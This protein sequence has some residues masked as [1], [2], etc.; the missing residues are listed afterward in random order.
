MTAGGGD[1]FDGEV[2]AEPGAGWHVVE[3]LEGGLG[4]EEFEVDAE[5]GGVG[6]GEGVYG[7]GEVLVVEAG[8][9]FVAADQA[10]V[11]LDDG[12]EGELDGTVVEHATE[13][14]F[15]GGGQRLG[16]HVITVRREPQDQVQRQSRR[17][18]GRPAT[19]R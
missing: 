12:L 10:V 14:L 2:D 11:E 5:A 3:A 18:K 15:G 7:A 13:D 19:T 6:G 17:P 8:E 16:V 1:G 4:G 9:G